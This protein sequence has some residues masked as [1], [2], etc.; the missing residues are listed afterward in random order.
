[1]K[2]GLKQKM[3][4]IIENIIIVP[5][6]IVAS[7]NNIFFPLKFNE[8]ILLVS[9]YYLLLFF[10]KAFLHKYISVDANTKRIL[11]T[12][13]LIALLVLSILLKGIVSR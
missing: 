10:Y 3:Y 12:Y 11:K 2:K 7:L 5:L 4:L 13:P 9:I 1:M 6:I 8:T